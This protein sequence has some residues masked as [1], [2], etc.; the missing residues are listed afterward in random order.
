[1]SLQK[2]DIV[3]VRT[4]IVGLTIAQEL[5]QRE[6]T[7]KV[8]IL[9]ISRFGWQGHSATAPVL[10]KEIYLRSYKTIYLKQICKLHISASIYSLHDI[11]VPF[12]VVNLTKIISGNV[13]VGPTTILAIRWGNYDQLR[14]QDPLDTRNRQTSPRHVLAQ[15]TT[16]LPPRSY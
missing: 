14:G 16:F 4:G 7:L 9:Y 15:S 13:Y 11:T 8:A 5:K 6:P 10:F 2:F 3:I 12:L 1:M